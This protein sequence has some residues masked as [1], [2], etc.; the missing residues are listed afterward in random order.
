MDRQ[1]VDRVDD[2]LV[3]E[4]QGLG[5]RRAPARGTVGP[6]AGR[7]CAARAGPA[8]PPRTGGTRSRRPR[9][10]TAAGRG[11]RCRGRADPV[12]AVGPAQGDD[13]DIA[14]ADRLPEEVEVLL[15][16]PREG[17]LHDAEVTQHLLDHP[18]DGRV[19]VA[20]ELEVRAVA[21]QDQR[22]EREHAGGGLVAAGEDAVGEPGDLLVADV[23]AH[24]RED[25]AQQAVARVDPLLAG[26]VEQEELALRDR[27]EGARPAGGDV[28][29]R[30]AERAEPRAVLGR[31]PEQ[32]ADDE[33]RDGEGELLDEVDDR[34]VRLHQ[35]ELRVDDGL[36]PRGQPVD[37]PHRELGRQEG[38]Q[39]G[40]LGRVGEAQPSDA[41]AGR[42]RHRAGCRC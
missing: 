17:D 14:L 31:E 24:R 41:R 26:G 13:D 27:P 18:V 36:D 25:P 42:A 8:R 23:V 12:V 39:A 38:P 20:D 21:Q 11:R 29:P 28:E 32:L 6:A 16:E 22:P 19:V 33:E 30:V 35:V 2:R 37:P 5:V 1:G 4:L 9:G 7:R 34:A 15:G 40:V 3:A 10:A